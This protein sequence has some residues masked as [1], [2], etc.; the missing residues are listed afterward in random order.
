MSYG[1]YAY[2]FWTLVLY[3]VL[4]TLFLTFSFIKPKNKF[5]WR[6]MGAFVG[7]IGA[8]FT[9]MYGAPLTIYFLTGWLGNEYPVTDPFS[10][11]SGHLWLVVIGLSHSVIALATLHIITNGII[12]L[13][14]YMVYKGWKLIYGAGEE[15]LVNEGIYSYIRHPQYIGLFLV[16]LGFFIQWPTMITLVMWPILMLTYFRLSM[17]EETN[18]A[19]KFGNEFYEYKKYVPAFFPTN[20]NIKMHKNI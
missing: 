12:F 3:S 6:S 4:I 1:G 18:L 9:E 14:F 17:R 8:L 7:F 10:H 19:N 20:K 5:E 2:G 15:Y 16:T 13:G 11:A